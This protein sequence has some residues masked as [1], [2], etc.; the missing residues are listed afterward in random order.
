MQYLYNEMEYVCDLCQRHFTS[1]RRLTYHVDHDVCQ[2][3]LH[4]CPLC[5]SVF[6]RDSCLQYHLEHKVCQNKKK[7]VLKM[8]P[9]NLIVNTPIESEQM[10]FPSREQLLTHSKEELVEQVLH[11]KQLGQLKDTEIRVLKENPKTVNFNI[12]TFGKEDPKKIQKKCPNLLHNAIM[13]DHTCQSI[14]YLTRK[15]HCNPEVFPEYE[16]V[17]LESLKAP[18]AMVYGEGQFHRQPKEETIGNLIANG[19]QLLGRHVEEFIEDEK[20]I[21]KYDSYLASVSTEDD[22][23]RKALEH[24]LIGILLD[25]GDRIKLDTRSKMILKNYMTK[26]DPNSAPVPNPDQSPDP[27]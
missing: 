10:S 15:I 26:T 17:Y 6:S 12:V 13:Q 20:I 4:K 18:Y 7:L 9:A 3:Q 16:N 1:K 11:E 21:Q 19:I 22:P 2:K 24:K 5:G 14:P 27:N 23:K 25:Q 8:S